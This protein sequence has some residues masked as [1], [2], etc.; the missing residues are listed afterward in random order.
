[1]IACC[2]QRCGL[3]CRRLRLH[4]SGWHQPVRS[5]RKSRPR[6]ARSEA[7][8]RYRKAGPITSVWFR[9][10]RRRSR[11]RRNCGLRPA[12][13]Q[14]REAWKIRALRR[15]SLIDAIPPPA[16]ARLLPMPRSIRTGRAN[17]WQDAGFTEPPH[18]EPRSDETDGGYTHLGTPHYRHSSL[19]CSHLFQ[20]LEPRSR[21]TR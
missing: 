4:S 20:L 11:N 19:C 1:M 13:A 7:R 15:T 12:C 5:S 14:R 10:T 18:Q 8:F 21:M 9:P 16:R 2:W 3:A 6:R 17:C